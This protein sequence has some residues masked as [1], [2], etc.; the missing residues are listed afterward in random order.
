MQLPGDKVEQIGANRQAAVGEVERLHRAV[1]ERIGEGLQ[2]DV[3]DFH[4]VDALD[5]LVDVPGLL[6]RVPIVDVIK[7]DMHDPHRF[8]LLNLRDRIGERF[9]RRVAGNQQAGNVVQFAHVAQTIAEGKRQLVTALFGDGQRGAVG[10]AIGPYPGTRRC[11]GDP[12][13]LF[14][15]LAYV[16]VDALVELLVALVAPGGFIVKTVRNRRFTA[17]LRVGLNSVV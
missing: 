6:G 3:G 12:G 11:A 2:E 17:T 7:I 5:E 14:A 13:N 8:A 16:G 15:H 9:D 1:A 10:C 4:V